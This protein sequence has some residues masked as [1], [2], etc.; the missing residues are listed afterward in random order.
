MG[1]GIGYIG[2]LHTVQ[3]LMLALSL[4]LCLGFRQLGTA[5]PRIMS[6]HCRNRP[7][8][9]TA[10][11][12]TVHKGESNTVQPG[13]VY[14]VATPIGNLE[15][16]TLRALKTLQEV[17]VIAAEDTRHTKTLLT[18]YNIPTKKIISHHEHN[19]KR[20]VP[21]IIRVCSL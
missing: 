13:R 4:R 3:L 16:I 14:F 2:K 15:D 11:L 8:F 17:D 7:L 5:L 19:W 10:S 9:Q 1:S 20:Q 18:H 21:T 6:L 12:H